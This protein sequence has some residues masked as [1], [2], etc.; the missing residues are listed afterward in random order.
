M[1]KEYESP[2]IQI[3]WFESAEDLAAYTRPTD[4]IPDTDSDDWFD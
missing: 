4:F 3:L 1:K 2:E